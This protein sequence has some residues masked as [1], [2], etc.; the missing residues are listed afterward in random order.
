MTESKSVAGK[1]S[2]SEGCPGSC[3]GV[4]KPVRLTVGDA[5]SDDSAPGSYQL[6]CGSIQTSLARSVGIE[7]HTVVTSYWNLGRH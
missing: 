4:E 7:I 6:L 1:Y 5:A 2:S 3:Q